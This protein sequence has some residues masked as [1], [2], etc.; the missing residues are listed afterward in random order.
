MA[1]LNGSALKRGLLSRSKEE[2]APFSGGNIVQVVAGALE[3]CFPGC[4]QRTCAQD[5]CWR[6]KMLTDHSDSEMEAE[7][8]LLQV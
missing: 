6:L 1:K 7:N 2:L 3:L 4:S 5:K 8:L